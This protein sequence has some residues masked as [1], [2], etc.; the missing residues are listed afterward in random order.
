VCTSCNTDAETVLQITHSIGDNS[1]FFT[2]SK[3][4]QCSLREY[5]SIS[6]DECLGFDEGEDDHKEGEA[7]ARAWFPEDIELNEWAVSKVCSE[8][9]SP[10]LNLEVCSRHS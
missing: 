10:A 9:S 1:K 3:P 7:L 4:M 2:S 6:A 5:H 8:A